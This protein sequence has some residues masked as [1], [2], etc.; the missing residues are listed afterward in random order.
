[1][2]L[3]WPQRGKEKTKILPVEK[4]FLAG[5]KPVVQSYSL[6]LQQI[7]ITASGIA[8]GAVF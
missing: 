8:G 6:T 5:E 7:V 2:P 1:M 4:N 3:V